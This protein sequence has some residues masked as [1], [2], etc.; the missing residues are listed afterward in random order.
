VRDGRWPEDRRRIKGLAFIDGDQIVAT[1]AA[2]TVKDIDSIDPD[3][4]ILEWEKYIYIPL[5]R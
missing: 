5:N 3:W 4:T 1:Q 2:P